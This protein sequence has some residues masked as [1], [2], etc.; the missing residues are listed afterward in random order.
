[1]T[2]EIPPAGS[3]RD[4]FSLLR[5][6]P[7]R[8]LIPALAVAIAA[9]VYAVRRPIAW[10]A[11]QA[12]MVRDEAAGT[13]HPGRFRVLDDMKTVQDTIME[14]VK[15]H[16]VLQGALRDVGPVAGRAADG[17]PSERDVATLD[18]AVK[19][20]PPHGAEFGKTAVFYLQVQDAD[21][22]RAIAL[23]AALSA[24]LQRR[25]EDLRDAT[26]QSVI[27]ESSKAVGVSQGALTDA[28]RRLAEMD[29]AA[30][31][32][33]GE[34][35]ILM[36][37]PSGDSPLRRSITEMAAE[38]RGAQTSLETNQELLALLRDAESDPGRLAAAPGKL[39]ES[40]PALKRL[41]DGLV[42][43]QL[44][45]ALLSGTM[46]D[47]HPQMVA[48]KQA[49]TEITAHLRSQLG[50]TIHGVESD[51]RVAEDRVE[52]LQQQLG[53]ARQRLERLAKIRAEYANLVTEVHRRDDTL[54]GAESQLSEARASQAAAHTASLLSQIDAPQAGLFPLG[55]SRAAIIAAG[56]GGGLLAGL[57]L[58]LL[59]VPIVVGGHHRVAE[60]A[61]STAEAAMLGAATTEGLAGNTGSLS[62]KQALSKIDQSKR[63]AR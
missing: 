8:W 60:G 49:E 12:L 62:F 55:P 45:R 23:A 13:D 6:Y 61:T 5:A 24:Q 2:H 26:S 56:C 39:L 37:A 11:S 50:S 18:A 59:T 33:L 4:V 17:W 36:D 38:L 54:K 7:F 16:S 19:L 52:V 10:E 53:E 15:S 48:A 42:D 30:G 63:V 31:A 35:R 47:E 43:A 28:T 20:S 21:R 14:L 46:S 51:V 32:D 44:H 1:M 3:L 22:D 25:F 34:L 27:D 29:A 57:G 40:Q 41:M 9:T 58:L